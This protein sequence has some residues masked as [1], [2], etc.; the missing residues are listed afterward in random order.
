MGKRL[1]VI[2]LLL[3]GVVCAQNTDLM[4]VEYMY[5]PQANS[6]NVVSRARA[7]IN[8]P[9]PMSWEGSY[10]IPGFE[11]RNINLDLNGDLPFETKGLNTLQQFR[12]TL[13]YTFKLKSEWRFGARAGIELASNYERS[14]FLGR[15]L[16][17]SG[18]FFFIKDRSGDEVEIPNRWIIGLQYSTNA[19]RPF[20]LPVVNYF[21]QFK[22][23]WSY[24]LGTPKTNLK[25]TLG[26]KHSLQA[27]IS[28][29][30]FFS[31]IQNNREF[32]NLDGTTQ[33]ADNIS[34]TQILG[35]L[36]Y[37]YYFS[38]HFLLYVYSAYTFYNELRLRDDSRNNV[39]TINQD[40]TVY[41]RTGLKYKL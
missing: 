24:S 31:N 25:H 41:F 16:R 20:P 32:V 1:F 21:R 37:E 5:T 9:I 33:I 2:F 13:A 39:F 6:E 12:A 11:Y 19:G 22:P 28:L 17:F 4:R 18:S 3:S 27:Y 8:F 35:G 15:D 30:G 10:L 14:D 26:K 36:G 29:D 34:M 23:N 7:F 40:N 38:E